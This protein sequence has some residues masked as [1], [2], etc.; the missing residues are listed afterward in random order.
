MPGFF[1]GVIATHALI[2]STIVT[3]AQLV[4]NIQTSGS[5]GVFLFP[6]ATIATFA[7]E[8]HSINSNGPLSAGWIVDGAGRSLTQNMTS[9]F[10]GL[11]PS[12]AA[13][14]IFRMVGK[15]EITAGGTFNT[16]TMQ[17]S[18]SSAT[19]DQQI[20]AQI[21]NTVTGAGLNNDDNK[22]NYFVLPYVSATAGSF[23]FFVKW[24]N[25]PVQLVNTFCQLS[26]IGYLT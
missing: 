1:E 22:N 6:S 2:N 10:P 3:M 25:Q 26:I 7:F 21:Y 24:P 12:T 8:T 9:V 14:V 18:N 20:Q 19:Y 16:M 4:T 23:R 17:A 13:G 5:K 11:I 15:L